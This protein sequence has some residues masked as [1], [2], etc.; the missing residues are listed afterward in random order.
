MAHNLV[1]QSPILSISGFSWLFK[2]IH[3]SALGIK[4]FVIWLQTFHREKDSSESKQKS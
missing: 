1:I 3:F 2:Y 4:A